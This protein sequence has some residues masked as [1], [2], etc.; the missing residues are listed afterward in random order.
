MAVANIEMPRMRLRANPSSEKKSAKV[1]KL[2]PHTQ[3][4]ATEATAFRKTG[5]KNIEE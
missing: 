1:E 2:T 5:R 3:R 4:T